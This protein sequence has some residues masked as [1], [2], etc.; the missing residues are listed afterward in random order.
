[1]LTLCGPRKLRVTFWWVTTITTFIFSRTAASAAHSQKSLSLYEWWYFLKDDDSLSQ[2]VLCS[3]QDF[4]F[5]FVFGR[6]DQRIILF[7]SSFKFLCL[8]RCSSTTWYE[9]LSGHLW[10]MYWRLKENFFIFLPLTARFL[11]ILPNQLLRLYHI[12]LSN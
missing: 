1:V 8:T 12:L 4:L 6:N 11:I 9:G 7:F 10:F 3:G 2:L 5:V